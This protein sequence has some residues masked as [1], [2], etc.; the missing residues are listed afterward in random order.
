LLSLKLKKG[1]VLKMGLSEKALMCK[2]KCPICSRAKRG[3]KFCKIIASMTRLIC[4]HCRAYE[5][6][7]G[8]KCPE[9]I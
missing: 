9:T 2:E 8:K 3:N 6:E 5:R 1:D 7:T 4:P